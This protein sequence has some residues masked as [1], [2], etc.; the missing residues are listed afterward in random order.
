MQYYGHI[1]RSIPYSVKK[2]HCI[3]LFGGPLD[4]FTVFLLVI[5]FSNVAFTNKAAKNIVH[6]PLPT[7]AII[8]E[9]QR[10]KSETAGA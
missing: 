8:I 7:H 3:P 2:Q 4:Y 9:G 5:D 10:P 1:S 6:M